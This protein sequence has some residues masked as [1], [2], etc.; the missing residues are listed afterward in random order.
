MNPSE[1]IK[2]PYCSKEIRASSLACPHCGRAIMSEKNSAPDIKTDDY[3]DKTSKQNPGGEALCWFCKTNK[4]DPAKAVVVPLW[5]T[6]DVETKLVH[7]NELAQKGDLVG[8]K[9]K[10]TYL[11][12]KVLVPCCEGCAKT[13]ARGGWFGVMGVLAWF[14]ISVLAGI[15]INY[16]YTHQENT[17]F[18]N[19]AFIFCCLFPAWGLLLYLCSKLPETFYLKAKKTLSRSEKKKY[20]RVRDLISDGYHF[21]EGPG[22]PSDSD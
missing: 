19:T 16:T 17:L 21:G 2:C 3:D 12:A 8:I 11:P 1:V 5:K 18:D 9:T 4:S 22:S 14:L 10:H 20:P 6:V 7:R 13:H 15:A